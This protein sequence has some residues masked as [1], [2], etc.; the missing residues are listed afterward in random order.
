MKKPRRITTFTVETERVYI[1]RTAGN[2]QIDW[3]SECAT[4]TQMASVADVAREAGLSELA[5][6]Q[7]LEARA[8]H[9]SED[10]DGRVFVCLNSLYLVLRSADIE[11]PGT[12][13]IRR[14]KNY[15][16]DE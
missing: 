2:S 11:A 14:E 5:I 3:C 16:N 8:L 15:E 9:F 13:Q 1:F 7:L 12:T 10:A 4:E 6:Y